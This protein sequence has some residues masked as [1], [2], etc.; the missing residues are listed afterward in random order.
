LGPGLALGLIPFIRK[1]GLSKLPA[2]AKLFYVIIAISMCFGIAMHWLRINPVKALLLTTVLYGIS[3]PFL[4]GIILHVSNNNKI[5][6][7]Y[8]N[9]RIS[10]IIGMM[11]LLLMLA[12]VVVLRYFLLVK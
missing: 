4:I 1:S 9:K 7:E 2:E 11:A 10:N 12:T 5:M 3:A 6:G 8:S